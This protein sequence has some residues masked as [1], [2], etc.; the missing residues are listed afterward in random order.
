[1]KGNKRPLNLFTVVDGWIV[2]SSG[3][4]SLF[5]CR[6]FGDTHPLESITVFLSEKRIPYSEAVQQNFQ[7]CKVGDAFG[8]T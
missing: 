6:L 3:L 1:M 2:L 7:P 5:H 8:P 4:N